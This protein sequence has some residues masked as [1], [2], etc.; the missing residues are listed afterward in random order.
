MIFIWL[1]YYVI[2]FFICFFLLKLIKNQFLK[3][4]FIPIILGIFGSFWF[5]EPGSNEI[6]PI[7]SILFLESTI[8]ESNGVER[9]IR[10]L[11]SSTLLIEI[12]SMFYYFYT[13]K[14]SKK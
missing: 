1:T 10:P 13:K 3:F 11:L 6:A 12:I 9:L 2:L 8:L 4:F 5:L 7:I 14:A